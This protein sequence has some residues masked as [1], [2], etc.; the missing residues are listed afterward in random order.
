MTFSRLICGQEFVLKI[1]ERCRLTKL[2][3]EGGSA[4]GCHELNVGVRPEIEAQQS[5]KMKLQTRELHPGAEHERVV[6]AVDE[7]AGYHAITAIHSTKLGPAVG[8][9]RVWPYA[10]FE[11]L[12]Q[13]RGR[14]N[15][16]RCVGRIC[17]D[18][19]CSR[20]TSSRVANAN[21]TREA[22]GFCFSVDESQ[23]QKAALFLHFCR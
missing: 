16:D 14:G 13:G 10:S 23:R 19:S 18:A 20:R 12:G 22:N 5:R 6:E 8:G 4:Y 21:A 11:A 2:R 1:K 15:E 7:A 9:T 3:G 17:P